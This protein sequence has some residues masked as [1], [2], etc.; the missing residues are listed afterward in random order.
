[1]N[2]FKYFLQIYYFIL[3]KKHNEKQNPNKLSKLSKKIA[4]YSLDGTIVKIFDSISEAATE[5]N[6][7][8]MCVSRCCND[9][10]IHYKTYKGLI[11]KYYNDE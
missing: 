10:Y 8:R 2:I 9:K 7:N 4:Q 3:N 6:I 5:L 11:W 1:M